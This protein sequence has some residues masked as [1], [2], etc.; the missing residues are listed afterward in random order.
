MAYART[1]Y[2][3]VDIRL[4]FREI[5]TNLTKGAQLDPGTGSYKLGS[6][7]GKGNFGLQPTPH[8]GI[9]GAD[10][11]HSHPLFA[12]ARITTGGATTHST[13]SEVEMV[14]A[15]VDAMNNAAMQPFL[16]QLD[17]GTDSVNVNVNYTNSPGTCN[18]F[19]K[20]GPGGVTQNLGQAV[21][22]LVLKIRRNP[23]N[24]NVPIIQTS[25]PYTVTQPQVTK[26]GVTVGFTV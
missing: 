19:K 1:N 13:M 8:P 2:T 3:A 5:D 7:Y 6:P 15:L 17:A 12:K 20:G 18:V 14:N 10:E 21:W 24:A 26:K 22:A 4:A 9:H 11:L 25:I 16:A 23:G